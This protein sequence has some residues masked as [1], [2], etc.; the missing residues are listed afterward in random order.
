MNRNLLRLIENHFPPNPELI[1]QYKRQD[2]FRCTHD[3]HSRF[4]HAVSV[5]HVLKVKQCYP[6][7]CT[8]FRWKCR[9]LNKG[10]SCP[11]KFRHVGRLC[12]SCR[13]FYDVK[14]INRPE[15]I[16]LQAQFK[17][18]Q[19][20]FKEFEDWIEERTGREVEF[21]GTI[22]SVKPEYLL[23]KVKKSSHVLLKGFLLTFYNCSINKISFNDTI[24]APISISMQNR[25][26]F[27]HGDVVFCSGYFTVNNGMVILRKI[28]R[29]EI[30]E[31][32]KSACWTESQAR[33]IQRTGTILPYQ[34]GKCH[35]C[36]NGTL[37]HVYHD[38]EHLP[39]SRVL[40]C[41]EGVSDLE[42]CSF[43]IKK[44]LTQTA[45]PQEDFNK[46]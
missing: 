2:I 33:V 23:R 24:Y 19:N 40:F 13:S 16:V 11:K 28:R 8:Y 22:S 6:D 30:H 9:N 14:E 31:K 3:S 46:V 17:L 41:L 36:E 29:I 7:G 42:L 5:Y 12:F 43:K 25:L 1:N 26:N 44:L 37:L 20:E 27:S 4:N 45:C 34:S 15:V 18:F 39:Q 32:N 38:G 35:A 21:S 10:I